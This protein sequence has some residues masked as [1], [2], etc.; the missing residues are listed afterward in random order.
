MAKLSWHRHEKGGW[1]CDC[2]C[3]CSRN[4]KA[5]RCLFFLLHIHL[6]SLFFSVPFS[7]TPAERQRVCGF[8][9]GQAARDLGG[10]TLPLCAQGLFDWL[11]DKLSLPSLPRPQSASHTELLTRSPLLSYHQNCPSPFTPTGR[12][13]CVWVCERKRERERKRMPSSLTVGYLK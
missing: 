8:Y 1:D 13:V 12:S 3:K 4:P 11:F 9:G 7:C 2:L 10:W 6:K 5:H